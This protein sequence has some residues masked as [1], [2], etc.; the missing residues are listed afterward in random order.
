MEKSAFV[1]LR[2][3]PHLQKTK[4]NVGAKLSLHV[5]FMAN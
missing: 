2:N 1:A 3:E 5:T 4:D